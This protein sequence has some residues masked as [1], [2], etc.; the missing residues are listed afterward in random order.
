MNRFDR[1]APPVDGFRTAILILSPNS[2][3]QLFDFMGTG[4][5]SVDSYFDTSFGEPQDFGYPLCRRRR[6]R[7]AL[8]VALVKTVTPRSTCY[9]PQQQSP[10]RTICCRV[11]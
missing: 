4:H 9:L 5:D 7:A 1:P 3:P 11:K 2:A 8:F 6:F 10:R